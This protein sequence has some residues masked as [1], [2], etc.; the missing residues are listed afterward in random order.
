MLGP[1]VLTFNERLKFS[2]RDQVAFADFNRP[3]FAAPQK[4][5]GVGAAHLRDLTPLMDSEK[6]FADYHLRAS[7]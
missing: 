5:V 7:Q 3:N 6:V 1:C 2:R 4:P